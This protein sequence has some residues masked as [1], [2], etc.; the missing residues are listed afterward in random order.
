M[1]GPLRSSAACC[2]SGWEPSL[3]PESGGG[4]SSRCSDSSSG[5]AGPRSD[6]LSGLT[7]SEICRLARWLDRDRRVEP[8]PGVVHDVTLGSHL[9]PADQAVGRAD[10]QSEPGGQFGPDK[11]HHL[12]CHPVDG[13]GTEHADGDTRAPERTEVVTRPAIDDR[14]TLSRPWPTWVPPTPN[15]S[16]DGDLVGAVYLE[17]EG[18]GSK[19]LVLGA[20]HGSPHRS[21]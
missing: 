18:I 16:A 19:E 1:V 20:Y 17:G 15:V 6:A 4:S 10:P 2:W 7:T 21:A 9:F 8:D 12:G 14:R 3:P 11:G 13:L 5:W